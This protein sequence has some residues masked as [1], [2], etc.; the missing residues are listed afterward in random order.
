MI[1]GGVGWAEATQCA[2]EAERASRHHAQRIDA[3][4]FNGYHNGYPLHRA[5][6]YIAL[7][8]LA[9]HFLLRTDTSRHARTLVTFAF[10]TWSS[11]LA[12]G[13]PLFFAPSPLESLSD[14]RVSHSQML[15]L[16]LGL[17][18]YPCVGC[19]SDGRRAARRP[20]ADRRDVCSGC[21]G[22]A[23]ARARRHLAGTTHGEFHIGNLQPVHQLKLFR[24]RHAP[25]RYPPARYPSPGETPEESMVGNLLA[26]DCQ[27][28]LR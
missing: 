1:Y 19:H 6:V 8:I 21:G 20:A 23:P 16:G 27:T 10:C 25:P 24:A 22:A 12:A 9:G 11:F 5:V 17:G 4:I 18:F 14:V 2:E 3:Q 28:S 13:R 26:R 7:F 15:G